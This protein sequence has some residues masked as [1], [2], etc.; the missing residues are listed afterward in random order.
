MSDRNK[1]PCKQHVFPLND[2]KPH[3]TESNDCWCNPEV[4]DFVVIHNSM[5]GRE[6]CEHGRK[7]Q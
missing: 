5:D 6:D 7:L 4:D 2:L 3:N 1:F